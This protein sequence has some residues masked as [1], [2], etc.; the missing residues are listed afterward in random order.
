MR[1]PP[2]STTA[3]LGILA[4]AVLLLRLPSLFEPAWSADEGTYADVGRSLDLGSV[5]YRDAWDNKPPGIYWLSAAVGLGHASVFRMQLLLLGFVAG[6]AVMVWALA[7]RLASNRAGVVAA[8]VYVTFASLPV[9]SGDQLNTEQIAAVPAAAAM[10]VLLGGHWSMAPRRCLTAGGVLALAW[11]ID[12]RTAADLVAVAAVPVLIAGAQR[13]RLRKTDWRAVGLVLAGWVAVLGVIAVPLA[14]GGSLPG[15]IDVVV[16]RDTGYLAYFQTQAAFGPGGAGSVEAAAIAVGAA[17]VLGVLLIG[18][19]LT[20]FLVRRA[21]ARGAVVAWWVACDLAAVMLDARGFTHYVQLAA[22]SLAIATVLPASV[23]LQRNTLLRAAAACACIVAAWPVALVALYVPP[24]TAALATGAPLP[25]LQDP[26]AARTPAYVTVG[27]ERV[28]GLVAPAAF[29]R[30][31]A[32][33]L[34]PLDLDIAAVFRAHSA[35]DESVFVWGGPGSPWAY[36]LADRRPSGRFVWMGSA[37]DTYQGA[38][39]IAINDLLA[40]PPAVLVAVQ[41]LPAR[42]Q[43]MLRSDRYRLLEAPPSLT[44]W[45]APWST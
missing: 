30:T 19:G 34:Y 26:E 44:C 28:L 18:G 24:A 16:N 38:R 25:A 9:F 5:L 14:A 15:F 2:R 22:P 20:L 7:H 21:S 39:A 1:W 3:A 12:V 6:G 29:D 37:Y 8:I 11:M 27:W 4:V 13:R 32:G 41:P 43:E 33:D 40:R 17:R 36:A 45:L 35:G 42:V 31:F 10:L 23:V